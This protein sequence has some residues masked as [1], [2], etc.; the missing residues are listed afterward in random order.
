MDFEQ[1]VNTPGS[2]IIPALILDLFIGDPV[3]PLHPIRLCGNLLSG[4]EKVLRKLKLN[5]YGGGIIL[6]S[7][8]S[9]LCLGVISGVSYAIRDLHPGIVYGWKLYI[10][11]SLIALGDLCKH[12]KHV[13]DAAEA[14]DLDAAR[15]HTGKLVGRDLERMQIPDCCR[16]TIESVSS[17]IFC[18]AFPGWWCSKWC[19]QWTAWS[20]IKMSATCGSGGAVRGWMMSLTIF[21]PASHG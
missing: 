7:L 6:F 12:G 14:G 16:A 1:F 8:L 20:V 3:Y 4:L 13:A 10:V 5:G 15:L 17:I 21:P 2:V 9:G 11:W 19:R 18:S